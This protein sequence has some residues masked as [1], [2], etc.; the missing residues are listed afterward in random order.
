MRKIV[1]KSS[2]V[3]LTLS[4]IGVLII[5]VGLLYLTGVSSWVDETTGSWDRSPFGFHYMDLIAYG[6]F[7]LSIGIFPVLSVLDARAKRTVKKTHVHLLLLTGIGI[8]LLIYST[9]VSGGYTSTFDPLHTWLDYFIVGALL[10]IFALLPFLFSVQNRERLWS[11]KF[12]FAAIVLVGLLL[13]VVAFLVYDQL[14]EAP[15]F[16][17]EL[18]LLIGM[19]VLFLG[20]APLLMTAG[21]GFSKFLHHLRFILILGVLLGIGLFLGSYLV[22]A[23]LLPSSLAL[24]IDWF[25]L[26]AASS[27]LLILTVSMLASVEEHHRAIHRLRLIWFTT[28]IIGVICVVISFVLILYKTEFGDIVGNLEELYEIRGDFFYLFGSVITIF[29]LVFICSDLFFETTELGITG[30]LMESAEDLTGIETT[31]S[32]M[33]AYLEILNKSQKYM[34]NQFKEAVRE[35]KFRPRVFEALVNQ[36]KDRSRAIAS[37]L[38]ALRK[39]GAII[40]GIEEVESLFDA[41]LGETPK[42]EP[43][44]TVPTAEAA[45]PVP[46]SA[47]S[48]P[49]PTTAPPP[50]PGPALPSTAPPPPSPMPAPPAPTIPTSQPPES[51]LDLIADAR[52][53]SIAELRGE[54]LKELRRLREIFKEE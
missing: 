4:G 46:P 19:I 20:L 3:L 54:M 35:D 12:L 37:R 47:P 17:W 30:E 53:T 7:L 1:V 8:L 41:A 45:P 32:E 28:L 16:G 40:T 5:I 34:V 43:E 27:L 44:P 13:L 11:F 10:I 25:V 49:A 15:G 6:A 22:Y 23:E 52:S 33:V 26:L 2:R 50:P 42:A 29:S 38:E 51:P 18:I 48:V 9:L 24:D 14:F 36:Y 31:S 39:K 21:Q